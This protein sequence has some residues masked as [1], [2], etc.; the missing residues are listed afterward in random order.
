MAE[1][2]DEKFL[3]EY[4]KL[5]NR[6]ENDPK[7]Q[8]TNPLLDIPAM[9][10]QHAAGV[11]A[12]QATDTTFHPHQINVNN[13]QDA[14][15]LVKPRIRQAR[16]ILRTCGATA[17]E[18]DDGMTIIRKVLGQRAAPKANNNPNTPENEADKS[19]S[20]S[21][22][23]YASQQGNIRSLGEYFGN[24]AKYKPNEADVKAQDFIDLAA[25][26]DGHNQKVGKSFVPWKA[27]LGTRDELLYN[28]PDSIFEVAKLAKE[29]YKGV[30]DG[31]GEQYRMVAAL[32]FKKPKQKK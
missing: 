6:V 9:K 30:Y 7:W 16:S 20:V 1:N 21:Q 31:K 18:I 32:R 24:V 4:L 23:S 5:I 29:Y 8:S 28:N 27:A 15:A 10:A 25:A 11:A 19:H 12:V 14:Y 17:N 13:R 3:E 2:T 22:L 26:L